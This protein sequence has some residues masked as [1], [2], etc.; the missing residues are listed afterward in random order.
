[1]LLLLDLEGLAILECPLDNVGLGRGALDELALLELRPELAEVLELDQV[2][3]IAEG[4]V[5]DGGLADRGGS[6][7]GRHC[8]LVQLAPCRCYGLGS[9]ILSVVCVEK[10]V[11]KFD[12]AIV[13]IFAWPQRHEE[14]PSHPTSILAY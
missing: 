11:L 6:G 3:D 10:E 8:E 13:C 12:E 14:S 5:D 7:D 4:C 1:M 2:P 9:E